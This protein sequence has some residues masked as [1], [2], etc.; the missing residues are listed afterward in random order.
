MQVKHLYA[1]KIQTQNKY[2][3]ITWKIWYTITVWNINT[4]LI[5][6]ESIKKFYKL[7]PIIDVLSKFPHITIFI[8]VYPFAGLWLSSIKAQLY[9]PEDSHGLSHISQVHRMGRSWEFTF[10]K[11]CQLMTYW[12]DNMKVQ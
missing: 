10:L 2:D 12:P 1:S 9:S 5:F 3:R 6:V 7:W 8:S 11:W 4:P